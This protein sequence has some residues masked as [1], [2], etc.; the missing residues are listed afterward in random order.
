MVVKYSKDS[1]HL[2]EVA[3]IFLEVLETHLVFEDLGVFEA[4][5]DLVK[6]DLSADGIEHRHYVFRN[7]VPLSTSSM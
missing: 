5:F 6:G 2:S 7:Q 1:E 4:V 3:E